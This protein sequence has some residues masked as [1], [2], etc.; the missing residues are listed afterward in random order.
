VNESPGALGVHARR[1]D[2]GELRVSFLSRGD[3]VRGRLCAQA[4]AA[5][6]L[7]LLG[8]P[9]GDAFG[10]YA[11]AALRD[12]SSWASVAAFDLPLCGG[13][14]S[15][16]LS[17][18]AFD[19]AAPLAR[20]LRSDLEAQV[21]CDLGRALDW[22]AGELPDAPRRTAFVGLGRSAELARTFC[23]REPRLDV[24]LLAVEPA[25]ALV[26]T[27]GADGDCVFERSLPSFEPRGSALAALARLLRAALEEG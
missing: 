18:L 22:V 16:K 20:T 21:E 7:V 17:A 26:L 27:R 15:E 2:E 10:V 24:A 5:A 6:P 4:S 8:A 23:E 3:R 12:F 11:S 25:Q 13:R 1:D 19:P 14:R 9:E